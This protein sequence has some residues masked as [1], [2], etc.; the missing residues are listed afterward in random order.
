MRLAV[1]I[2][3]FGLLSNN[4]F[5]QEKLKEERVKLNDSTYI[6]YFD[7]FNDH[8][9]FD[10]DTVPKNFNFGNYRF[11]FKNNSEDTLWAG[12]VTTG[13]GRVTYHY[14][15]NQ[16]MILPGEYFIIK[17][18]HNGDLRY[19]NWR[20]SKSVSMSASI[21]TADSM[22]NVRTYHRYH[23]WYSKDTNL[24]AQPRI[25][26][27]EP[28]NPGP[29]GIETRIRQQRYEERMKAS[30][31]RRTRRKEEREQAQKHLRDSLRQLVIN[32][33]KRGEIN[34][35]VKVNFTFFGKQLSDSATVVQITNSGDRKL[36]SIIKKGYFP[37]YEIQNYDTLI[38]T[39]VI[40]YDEI[41]KSKCTLSVDMSS[42]KFARVNWNGNSS[43]SATYS[44][45]L[46]L[47][48][49]TENNQ[50]PRVYNIFIYD[51][52]NISGV[53]QLEVLENNHWVE[54]VLNQHSEYFIYST[55]CTD[56]TMQ[57]RWRTLNSGWEYDKIYLNRHKYQW[58]SKVNTPNLFT[59][60]GPKPVRYKT[61]EFKLSYSLSFPDGGAFNSKSALV[62]SMKRVLKW[63][64]IPY[65]FVEIDR[66]K[67]TNEDDVIRTQRAFTK[68]FK[69][70]SNTYLLPI[71]DKEKGETW[72][73][74]AVE[75][76]FMKEISKD[77]IAQIMKDNGIRTYAI[78]STKVNDRLVVR[79]E[80]TNWVNQEAWEI[81]KRF[82]E[83]E[84]LYSVRSL[85]SYKLPATN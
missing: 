70:I 42:M 10:W 11:Y 19:R 67:L 20:F 59:S 24:V 13:D 82:Y 55:V 41:R 75:L 35:K 29:D 47:L 83:N 2:I 65:E 69:D 1:I 48:Q 23:G 15:G 54:V 28:L 76:Q 14:A 3:L 64:G 8:R 60:N 7:F 44:N 43:I 38:S 78:Q 6:Y 50:K 37:F 56:N 40:V 17:P 33:W 4:T 30:E 26:L 22:Y 21:Y 73:N 27:D 46:N 80:L 81:I 71:I 53:C 66:I 34:D 77:R 85:T 51:T 16:K 31:E 9:C 39:Q 79:F 36:N 84:E 68:H 72:L 25:K 12:R 32:K 62:D 61:T 63:Y 5:S 57:V 18:M 49:E 58:I 74:G 52:E 45:Y